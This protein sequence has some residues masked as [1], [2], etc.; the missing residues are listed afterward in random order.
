MFV[1]PRGISISLTTFGGSAP[2]VQYDHLGRHVDDLVGEPRC[3]RESAYSRLGF[4]G[5]SSMSSARTLSPP[6]PCGTCGPPSS[7]QVEL[8]DLL[9]PVGDGVDL[10]Q[11]PGVP[12]EVGDL[13]PLVSIVATISSL[14]P[15]EDVEL[16]VEHPLQE[17]VLAECRGVARSEEQGRP[18]QH[19]R[20]KTVLFIVSFPPWGY[21]V[22][23]A[24]PR[25]PTTP[26]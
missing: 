12:G 26:A 19:Q 23:R 9:P 5:L 18:E 14:S 11:V 22:S 6:T 2:D 8:F 3:R 15:F 25:L 21:S 10:V 13:L 24:A 16:V 4:T 1:Q 20:E 17:D 7:L